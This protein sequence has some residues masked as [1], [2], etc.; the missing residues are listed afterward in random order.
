MILASG[1]WA[2]WQTR[3]EQKV[4]EFL[5]AVN[6]S[7]YPKLSQLLSADDTKWTSEQA[8]AFV[9]YLENQEIGLEELLKQ[10]QVEK[11]TPYT[12]QNDNKLLGLVEAGKKWLFF[13]RYEFVTYPLEL[14]ASSDLEDLTIDGQVVESGEAV[15]VAS[16]PFLP[17]EVEIKGQS[18]LGPIET[19]IHLDLDQASHNRLNLPLTLTKRRF[20]V[21][22]PVDED[23][24]EQVTIWINGQEV[25][26]DLVAEVDSLESQ[27]LEIQANFTVRGQDFETEVYVV[28][29]SSEEQVSLALTDDNQKRLESVLS[30]P[31]EKRQPKVLWNSDKDKALARFMVDWGNSMNQPGYKDLTATER[32]FV[33]ENRVKL[34]D[35]QDVTTEFSKDGTG[36]SDYQVL[37]IYRYAYMSNLMHTYYFTIRADGTPI[38]LYSAQNQGQPDN[39]FYMKETANEDL[40]AGFAQIVNR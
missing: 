7:D 26:Q 14:T 37:A 2:Y 6:Q 40:K 15:P 10:V 36:N 8:E 28:L 29:D 24:L 22:L 25:A 17:K 38:V 4:K 13:P 34:N 21:D 12:D 20:E 11:G 33:D 23:D 18:P 19:T 27:L 30:K 3:P 31:A 9:T 35:V 16:L 39:K 5:T 1:A 32:G